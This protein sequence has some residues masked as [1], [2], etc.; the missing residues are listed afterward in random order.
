MT[1]DAPIFHNWRPIERLDDPA[2]LSL[3]E[4]RALEKLWQ[5]QRARLEQ[6][7]RWTP[8]WDRMVRWWCVE[9]G[10][11]ERVFDLDVGVTKILVT[12]GFVASLIPHGEC[13]QPADQ[14]IAIL[15]DHKASIDMV[16]DVVGGTRPL[17][18]GWIRE[19]HALICAHQPTTRAMT[20]DGTWV[21][22]PLRKGD[23]KTRPNS[24]HRQDGSIHEYC[25]PEQVAS[26]MDQL[27]AHYHEIPPEFPE[28]RAAWLHHAFT[29]IHPFEDGNGRV[30]RALASV[31]FLRAGLFP[32]LVLRGDKHTEYLPALEKAD[33]GDLVPLVQL[34]CQREQRMVTRAISEAEVVLE[35]AGALDSVLAA[36]RSKI[37]ERNHTQVKDRERMRGRLSALAG[38]GKLRLDQ[39]SQEITGK[40]PGCV[41]KTSIVTADTAHYFRKQIVD[42]AK[43]EEYWADLREAWQWI[44]LQ[45]VDGGVTDIVV[46]LHFTGNPSPGSCVAT[47][48]VEH[49]AKHEDEFGSD[50]LPLE[51]DSLFLYPTEVEQA[52]TT[53]FSAWLE[54]AL[55]KALAVWVRYL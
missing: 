16:M 44:R 51:I 10:V 1:P 13:D 28:V 6:H 38:T 39:A 45:I 5:M 40:V 15:N 37:D 19:L 23:W 52:Q 3:P 26:E 20:P 17:T 11:L 7:R 53:R 55:K 27:V 46:V 36:A 32:V 8:F 49:R 18:V 41:A 22:L 35:S 43:R 24:P 21:E 47:A 4:M 50:I 30:A 12:Q 54:E 29:C 2:K 31:D 33:S 25:P 34:F 9:T 14:V 42:I 48:F